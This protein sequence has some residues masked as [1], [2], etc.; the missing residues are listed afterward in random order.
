MESRMTGSNTTIY[1][2]PAC[3]P[4]R[5]RYCF[6][7]KR[8]VGGPRGVEWEVIEVEIDLSTPGP[9][10]IFSRVSWQ[11]TVQR[12]TYR[13]HDSDDD[14]LLYL[15]LGRR[16][17]PRASPSVRLLRVGKPDKWRVAKIERVDKLRLSGISVDR[18]AGFVIISE[19]EDWTWSPRDCSYICWLDERKAGDAVYSR[20]KQLISSWSRGLLRRF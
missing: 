8:F 12:P 1:S 14:L 17:Q 7:I 10:K 13:L 19:A 4:T 11:Y 18:D 6:I 20:T 16:G 2:I 15:P 9:I 3:T 5:P